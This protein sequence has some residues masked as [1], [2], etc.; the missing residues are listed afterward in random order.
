M[1]PRPDLGADD[2]WGLGSIPAAG[3]QPDALFMNL[4]GRA[5]IAVVATIVAADLSLIVLGVPRMWALAATL[6]VTL[7]GTLG[8]A[9]A[10]GRRARRLQG[11]TRPRRMA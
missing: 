3:W 4:T 5:S 10:I 1:G 6:L 8:L 11:S 2:N 9:L 7:L